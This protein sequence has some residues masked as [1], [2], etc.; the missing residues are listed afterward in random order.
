M[1]LCKFY[2][3]PL[4][5]HLLFYCSV[6]RR[7]TVLVLQF[8][9]ILPV[10]RCVARSRWKQH[11]L[12]AQILKPR[13]L[14][15]ASQHRIGLCASR[16]HNSLFPGSHS[17]PTSL[18][19]PTQPKCN[20]FWPISPHLIPVLGTVFWLWP[21]ACPLVFILETPSG[22]VVLIQW[23]LLE[24]AFTFAKTLSVIY[25]IRFSLDS[26]VSPPEML[27]FVPQD[28]KKTKPGTMYLLPEQS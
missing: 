7:C 25:P 22:Y 10:S 8:C 23:S 4:N 28:V 19:S 1:C 3:T 12:Q 15:H 5:I 2:I 16:I 9:V 14:P 11:W 6:R 18:C 20:Q 24:P 21:S 27:I 17:D 26:K 13:A